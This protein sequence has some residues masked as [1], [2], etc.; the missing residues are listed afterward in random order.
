MRTDRVYLS[1][2]LS[3]SLPL[4]L[5]LY[6]YM[7]VYIIHVTSIELTVFASEDPGRFSS[8]LSISLC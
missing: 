7:C 3:L 6:T 8:V 4:P 2:S 1:L 5:S